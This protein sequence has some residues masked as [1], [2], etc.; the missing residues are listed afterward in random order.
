MLYILYLYCILRTII[1]TYTI[2]RYYVISDPPHKQHL[3]QLGLY[4]GFYDFTNYDLKQPFNFKSDHMI[5]P[6]LSRHLNVSNFNVFSNTTI[7]GVI[8]LKSPY[9]G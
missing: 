3:H 8:I 5:S 9:E 6:P 1:H 2:V 7:V 4:M